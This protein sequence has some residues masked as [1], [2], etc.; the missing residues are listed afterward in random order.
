MLQSSHPALRPP[1]PLVTLTLLVTMLTGAARARGPVL[2]FTNARAT[3]VVYSLTPLGDPIPHVATYT[4]RHIPRA[5]ECPGAPRH[6]PV[7][8]VAPV[9]LGGHPRASRHRD[10]GLL[11]QVRCRG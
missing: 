3:G 1:A 8:V 4:A 10:R 5:R 9:R 2:E 11:L 7:V 6:G